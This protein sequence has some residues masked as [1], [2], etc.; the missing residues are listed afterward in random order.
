MDKKKKKFEIPYL[1]MRYQICLYIITFIVDLAAILSSGST[2]ISMTVRSVVSAA[3][4][5]LLLI[6]I[7]Y[8]QKYFFRDMNNIIKC[9]IKKH[10]LLDYLDSHYRERTFMSAVPGFTVN[11]LFTAFNLFIGIRQISAWYIT[12]G[13]YYLML[14]IMRF[15]F[16]HYEI[17]NRKK[18][19]VTEKQEWRLF[20]QYGWALILMSIVLSGMVI[21]VVNKG[22]G[23]EYPAYIIYVVAIYT[24]IK[25]ISATVNMVKARKFKSPQVMGI[26]NIGY[27]DALVSILSLQTAMFT[28][29]DERNIELRTKMNEI[30]GTCV[31]TA[32]IFIGI[33]MVISAERKLKNDTHF[34]SRG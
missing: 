16:L 15:R 10:P 32:V 25:V 2:K 24:F 23:K 11:C 12:L 6:S 22:A 18:K 19:L 5:I 7:I 17:G 13:V 3:A 27:A 29:F 33:M 34:S 4:F 20:F 9:F 26:R 1:R 8:I 30:T 31:C 21:L 14:G 28:I